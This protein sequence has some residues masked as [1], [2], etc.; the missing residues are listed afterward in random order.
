MATAGLLQGP[1][2]AEGVKGAPRKQLWAPAPT[3]L[4]LGGGF[5]ILVSPF[6]LGTLGKTS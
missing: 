5:V 6:S 4:V 3:T 2:G 1:G